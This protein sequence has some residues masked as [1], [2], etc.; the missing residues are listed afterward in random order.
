MVHLMANGVACLLVASKAFRAP[1]DT[2][3]TQTLWYIIQVWNTT[4]NMVYYTL[5][6]C[7]IL[8]YIIIYDLIM[9]Y[10]I[11]YN[12]VLYKSII[13]YYNILYYIML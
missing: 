3:Q 2:F 1:W 7:Y 10:T 8:L 5:L 9:L 4:E 13:Y 6:Q 11:V 12:K